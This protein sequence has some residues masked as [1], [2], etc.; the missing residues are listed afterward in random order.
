[1]VSIN[2]QDFIDPGTGS[3]TMKHNI[4]HATLRASHFSIGDKC[5]SL[6]DHYATTYSSTMQAKEQIKN[7]KVDNANFKSSI[8][9][10]GKDPVNYQTESR[11]K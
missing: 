7:D 3:G 1:M 11:A 10:S 2:K 4:N 5:Q 8:T 9:I 6:P